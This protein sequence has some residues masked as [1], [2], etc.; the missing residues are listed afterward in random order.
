MS[1]AWPAATHLLPNCGRRFAKTTNTFSDDCERDEET[2]CPATSCA[3]TGWSC[4]S[5][6]SSKNVAQ[7]WKRKQHT[8]QAN[9]SNPIQ[10]RPDVRHGLMIS[11]RSLAQLR[12]ETLHSEDNMSDTTLK[13][14]LRLF[15]QA[16]PAP[17]IS[18]RE[19]RAIR[20]NYERLKAERLAL[21]R[22]ERS[23]VTSPVYSQLRTYRGTAITDAMCQQETHA[24]QQT[25]ALSPA[26]AAVDNARCLRC[27]QSAPSYIL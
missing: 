22:S 13:E 7:S 2:R 3:R 12:S 11:E 4:R 23:S 18:E 19:Q 1:R 6:I 27:G 8:L 17:T 16:E 5:L 14:A 26:R 24:P 20:A 9:N 15:K 10:P 25:A 21:R